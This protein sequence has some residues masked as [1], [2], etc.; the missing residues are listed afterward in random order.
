MDLGSISLVNW[1]V[2]ILNPFCSC[3]CCSAAAAVVVVIWCCCCCA[4][5][6]DGVGLV[7]DCGCG[8]DE[9][10]SV[11]G[12][13]VCLVVSPSLDSMML[14]GGDVVVGDVGRRC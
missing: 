6:D 9:G 1:A 2:L 7:G 3:C 8:S 11:M 14:V 13:S 12:C 5:D 4:D 10:G